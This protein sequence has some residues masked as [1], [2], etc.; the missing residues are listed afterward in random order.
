MNYFP[1]YI[2]LNGHEIS[3]S[4]RS[5]DFDYCTDCGAKVVHRCIFCSSEIKGHPYGEC[6]YFDVPSYCH[7]CG[8]PYPWTEAAIQ[9]TM[10][11]LAEDEHITTDECNRLA[12][13]LPDAISQT[14]RTNLAA[15]RI[16]KALKVLGNFAADGLKQF[17]L[18]FGCEVIRQ[19]LGL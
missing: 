7:A 15:V 3:S 13:I 19:Q 4:N 12:E 1:A 14:P 17:I 16:G 10:E 6:G 9:A 8:K 18:D 11:L 5:C 2:C